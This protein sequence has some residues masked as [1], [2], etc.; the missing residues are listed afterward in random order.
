M[1]EQPEGRLLREVEAVVVSDS[2]HHIM[3]RLES[4]KCPRSHTDEAN[5]I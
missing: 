5:A 2:P 3:K 1:K 4:Q